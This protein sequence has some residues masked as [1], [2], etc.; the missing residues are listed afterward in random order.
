[1]SDIYN[2]PRILEK[3]IRASLS[4]LDKVTIL[5]GARQ[6][7]KTTLLKKLLEPR[8]DRVLAINADEE[9]HIDLL[10]SRDAR[11]LTSFVSGYDVL[12]IDEAQR[13]PDIGINLKILIDEVRGLKIVATGSSS[14][15]LASHVSEPLTG[16]KQTFVLHPIAWCEIAAAYR[17]AE[18][19]AMLDERVV[20]GSYPTLFR[21]PAAIER[22]RYLRELT[23]D[24]LYKDILRIAEVRNSSK[25]RELLKLL[26]FQVGN[27][28]SLSELGAQLSISKDTVARYLDLLEKV[29]VIFSLGGY[30]GNLRKEVTRM[31]KYY[32]WDTGFRN[33]LVEDLS[34]LGT[35]RDRGALWEN[36]LIAERL[37]R[38]SYF[39]QFCTPYFWR[40]YTGAEVDYVEHAHGTLHGY[41][42]KF[43]TARAAPPS[44]WLE[45]YSDASWSLVNAES[46]ETFV[47][48]PTA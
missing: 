9:R 17:P 21:I 4:L 20:F 38:N 23:S 11:A 31:K 44:G 43:G 1:M 30:S 28:V 24:Y 14:F 16:R 33:V 46:W 18:Q 25:L 15:E 13:I 45:N 26:A 37:K 8:G 2:I 40:V 10:S 3:N 41:E 29:F 19:K 34:P 42:F 39:D 35:R 48:A 22:E 36:F 7:G 5:Y 47:G 27:E 6:V 12:F 32:F